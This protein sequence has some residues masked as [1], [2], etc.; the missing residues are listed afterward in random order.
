MKFYPPVHFQSPDAGGQF[1]SP[2]PLGKDISD[3]PRLLTAVAESMGEVLEKKDI[4]WGWQCEAKKGQFLV[5][6]KHLE[7]LDSHP[8]IISSRNREARVNWSSFSASGT[9]DYSLSEVI[10]GIQ[11]FRKD[12]SAVTDTEGPIE[13]I[14]AYDLVP[15]AMG[16]NWGVISP[17]YM[18]ATSRTGRNRK[19]VSSVYNP[20]AVSIEQYLKTHPENKTNVVAAYNTMVDSMSEK[21]IKLH[22]ITN[23]DSQDFSQIQH[24]VD[25][26]LPVSIQSFDHQTKKAVFFLSD[27]GNIPNKV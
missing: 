1:G 13:V 10:D 27:F 20:D 22:R 2:L 16:E 5:V 12:V 17:D 9:N 26:A 23:P 3:C 4:G 15:N 19:S 14:K 24:G 18:F 11:V 7:F 8:G 6:K 21:G 25:V